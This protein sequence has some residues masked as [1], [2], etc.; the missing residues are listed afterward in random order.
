MKTFDRFKKKPKTIPQS[1]YLLN[2][3]TLKELNHYCREEIYAL[4]NSSCIKP[5]HY[6]TD[7]KCSLYDISHYNNF[8]LK[9]MDDLGITKKASKK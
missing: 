9:E 6:N 5:I 4:S 7:I 3:L 2:S 8:N 1:A